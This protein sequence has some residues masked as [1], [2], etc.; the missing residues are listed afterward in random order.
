MTLERNGVMSQINIINVTFGYEGSYDTIFDSVSFSIDSNWKLGLIGR[1]GRGKTTFLN[2]LLGKYRYEGMIT[3]SVNF[4]YFPYRIKEIDRSKLTIDLFEQLA[5]NYELWKVCR[6]CE[7]LQLDT[8]L[9]YRPYNTLSY[10]EQTKVMLALLFSEEEHFLLIDEPTNHLDMEARKVVEKY[11]NT[12][13]GFILVSHDRRLLDACV[14]HILSINRNNIEV[15]RGNFSSWWENK[16]RQDAFEL[17]ENKKH[18]KEIHKLEESARRTARWA[19]KVESQKI[20]FNPKKEPERCID[21]RAYIGEKSRRMQQRRKNLERRQQKTIEKKSELLQNIEESKELKLLFGEHHKETYLR[22]AQV[23]LSYG[24]KN[25]IHNLSFEL[26][27]GQCLVLQ[28]KNGCGKS[29]VV[30]T[31][32][33]N[34]N[35]I[36]CNQSHQEFLP[37]IL[38]QRGEIQVAKALN[39]I[40]V[41]SRMQIESLLQ[42]YRP[43]M[44]LIEHDQQFCQTVG[45]K[46]LKLDTK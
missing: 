41:F 40:D 28:G 35:V 33:K 9:F 37:D 42:A 34:E 39:Y 45:T 1:N 18:K 27:R 7:Y 43:T 21:T 46:A 31:I 14:D 5:P 4:D 6:E 24:E 2:L 23:D 3:S 13:K 36:V 19:D 44:L 12:K 20:G 8:E 30:K 16:R 29:S 38:C 25:V 32:L 22:F 17:A 26:K 11:L 15:Q 10:G